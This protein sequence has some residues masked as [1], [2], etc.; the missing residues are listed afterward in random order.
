KHVRVVPVDVG[1]DGK[2]RREVQELRPRVEDRRGVFVA[3]EDEVATTTPGRRG[4]EV[5][6]GHAQ[7]ESRVAAGG[8]QDPGNQARR[9]RLPRGARYDDAKAIGRQLPQYSASLI[10]RMCKRRAASVSGLPS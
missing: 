4:A 8:A 2:L 7:P 3:F 5:F 1:Q 6:D 10:R 9:R